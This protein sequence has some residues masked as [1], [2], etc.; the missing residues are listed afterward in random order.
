M[1]GRWKIHL[2]M[3]VSGDYTGAEIRVRNDSELSVHY[4]NIWD[5]ECVQ[6]DPNYGVRYGKLISNDPSVAAPCFANNNW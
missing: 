2:V 1:R 6:T 4:N 3:I 5:A